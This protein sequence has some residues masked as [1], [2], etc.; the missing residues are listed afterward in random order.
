M[1]QVADQVGQSAIK[2]TSPVTHAG[3]ELQT[4]PLATFL[5]ERPK[6]TPRNDLPASGELFAYQHS[7]GFL[8]ANLPRRG[9]SPEK[10]ALAGPR[11]AS[12]NDT[13]RGRHRTDHLLPPVAGV[14]AA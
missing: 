10:R 9:Q 14:S 7:R 2:E 5:G 12:D 11:P 4:H 1:I 8:V 6:I 3:S 13:L